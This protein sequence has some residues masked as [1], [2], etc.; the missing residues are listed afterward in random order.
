[1]GRGSIRRCWKRWDAQDTTDCLECGSALRLGREFGGLEQCRF[2][3]WISRFR[4]RLLMLR[5]PGRGALSRH[6][7]LRVHRDLVELLQDLPSLL[8]GSWPST[9]SAYSRQTSGGGDQIEAAH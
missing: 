4:R 2:G 8:Q 7:L 9:T 6:R 3:E 5:V 1:M